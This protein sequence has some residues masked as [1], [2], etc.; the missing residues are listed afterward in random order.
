MHLTLH[1]EVIWVRVNHKDCPGNDP[2]EMRQQQWSWVGD[3]LP[4]LE[5]WK[6]HPSHPQ[7]TEEWKRFWILTSFPPRTM[8]SKIWLNKIRKLIPIHR[9][10][11]KKVGN[12]IL[13]TE[14]YVAPPPRSHLY[15]P[16]NEIFTKSIFSRFLLRLSRIKCF[17]VMSLSKLGPTAPI[18][19]YD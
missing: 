19:G 14:G 15:L 13:T 3:T 1:G 10:S 4:W 17:Q 16:L 18:F 12:R 7:F 2:A 5:A 9:V 8:Y 6:S 11:Q